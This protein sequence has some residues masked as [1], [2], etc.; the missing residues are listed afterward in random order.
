MRCKRRG[1]CFCHVRPDTTCAADEGD[2][3]WRAIGQLRNARLDGWE[4]GHGVVCEMEMVVQACGIRDM[5]YLGIWP[6]TPF[7]LYYHVGSCRKV[8]NVR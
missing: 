8:L 6:P 7:A 2:D 1:K 5:F 3:E 4:V